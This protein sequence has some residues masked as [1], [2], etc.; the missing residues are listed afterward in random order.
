MFPSS[1]PF[2][3]KTIIDDNAGNLAAAEREAAKL[4]K[5]TRKKGKDKAKKQSQEQL[6]DA[7]EA[8]LEA[9]QQAAADSATTFAAIQE[10]IA[11]STEPKPQGRIGNYG[12]YLIG[13]MRAMS[14]S[15]YK[16]FK[17]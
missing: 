5:E 2:Q 9:L 1:V 3:L 15:R 11:K 8:D 4:G 14:K 16:A 13:E 10:S 6:M 17:R 7:N 12:T